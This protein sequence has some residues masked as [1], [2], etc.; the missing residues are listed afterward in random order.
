MSSLISQR[1]PHLRYQRAFGR[2]DSDQLR[3]SGLLDHRLRLRD[4]GLIE[5]HRMHA[6]RPDPRGRRERMFEDCAIIFSWHIAAE[7]APKL[8]AKDFK[9]KLITPLPTPHFL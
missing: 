1:S 9:G 5:D 8:R 2:I 6:G 7:L 4:R 3:R